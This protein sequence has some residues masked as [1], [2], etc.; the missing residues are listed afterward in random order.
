[1]KKLVLK[2]GWGNNSLG[3]VFAFGS[4]F[5][6]QEA[7]EDKKKQLGMVAYGCNPSTGEA[8]TGSLLSKSQDSKRSCLGGRW[9]LRSGTPSCSLC[10]TRIYT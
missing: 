5:D 4:K 7:T 2:A 1:M 6:S 3:K 9:C 10:P 8:E